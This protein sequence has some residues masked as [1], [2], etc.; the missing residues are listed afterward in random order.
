MKL[1]EVRFK[2]YGL[3]PANRDRD[4]LQSEDPKRTDYHEDLGVDFE[5]RV[6][7]LG[8]YCYPFEIVARLKVAKP[9]RGRPPK[10]D[11]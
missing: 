10:V 5:R 8:E 2:T 7:T 3:D 4:W 1:A 11:K 6:V 9:K